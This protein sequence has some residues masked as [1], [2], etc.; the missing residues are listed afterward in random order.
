VKL[1]THHQLMPRSRMRVSIHLLSHTF[2]WPSAKLVKH[3]DNFTLLYTFYLMLF[4]VPE[5]DLVDA[6]HI[7]KQL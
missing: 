3:R 1:A 6:S 7:S 5:V 4:G 2:S